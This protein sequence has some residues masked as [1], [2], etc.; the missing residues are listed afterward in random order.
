MTRSIKFRRSNE[1]I[2]YE[3]DRPGLTGNAFMPSTAIVPLVQHKGS[4]ARSVVSVGD[5]VTEGQL[6]GRAG[7]P[8]SVHVH[9]PIPGM[10]KEFRTIPLPDGTMGQ[11]A[12][13]QLAGSFGISGRKE[14]H[15]SWKNMGPLEILKILEERGVINTC[16]V[17]VPLVPQ[18]RE[19]TKNKKP[20]VVIRLFDNDP[21]C[22]LDE[23]LV[24]IALD[25][26]LEGAG[27]V[28]RSI[29]SEEVVFVHAHKKTS[30][31]DPAQVSSIFEKNTV[32]HIVSN[33]TYPSGN[34]SQLRSLVSDKCADLAS[35]TLVFIEPV[36]AVSVH[37]A[38]V[39]NQPVM[40]R[41]ILMQGPAIDKPVILK[42]KIGTPIG[43]LIEE[44]GGFRADPSRI[45]VN[46]LLSGTAVYDLDTPVTKYM[47]SIHLMDNDSCPH[48]SSEDCIHCGRCMQ[49][50]PVH[51]DPMHV[52]VA[53]RKER[54]GEGIGEAIDTCQ[55][56]GCCAIVCPSR[57][58]LHH[59]IRE[60]A[61]GAKEVLS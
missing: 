16:E 12:C 24:D 61:S 32:R 13:I 1:H 3:I 51:I 58:P 25:E 11:A 37:D 60:A 33:G 46:G 5:S 49:V 45:V 35:R 21:T 40:Y 43:D 31:P 52:V 48:Y 47:K 7:A 15:Y 56:C 57:I 9:S 38:I 59:I 6:I 54:T 30:Q 42:A 28:A 18:L 8:D 50:C 55:G 22:G 44:C 41:Y 20:V 29:S 23:S 53:I 19:A 36:T 17:P 4:A 27:I 26:V 34:I 10:I 39:K 2:V 14:E